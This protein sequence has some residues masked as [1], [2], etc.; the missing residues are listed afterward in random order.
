MLEKGCELLAGLALVAV[1]A[2]DVFLTVIVPRAVSR[3]WRPSA[4]L[5]RYSWLIA[6]RLGQG[7]LDGEMREEYLSKYAP[8][9][10]SI[11]LFF[12]L[13]ALIAGYGII[14]YAL[15]AALRPEVS[16]GDALYFAGTSFLTIGYGDI[17][18]T[19]GFTRFFSLLAGATGFGVVAVTTSFL[20]AIFG[21]F[22]EREVFVVTLTARA[23]SPPSGLD[24]LSGAARAG[25]TDQMP[26]LFREGERW[27]AALMESHLAYPI[28]AFFRSSHDEQSWVATLGAMLDA[29]TLCITTL[30]GYDGEAQW[31]LEL[32]RHAVVD[33][34][35][36]FALYVEGEAGIDR[37]EFAGAHAQLTA[38][39]LTTIDLDEA[40]EHFARVR[41][42]YA[43]PLNAMARFFDIPPARWVGDRSLLHHGAAIR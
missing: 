38:L 17:V 8:F 42:T 14:F 36:Y 7:I 18:P 11:T 4:H 3:R 9:A 28:L 23:G 1:V 19:G 30:R 13:F 43:A 32:G 2:S 16:F 5:T 39:G 34:S 26:G 24:L 25:L 20:F 29:A 35:R 12:W 10:L 33:L 40:W 15:R 41:A 27:A 37:S 22:Q 21:S 6:D 31:M